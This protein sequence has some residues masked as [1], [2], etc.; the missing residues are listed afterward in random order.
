[1][2]KI[3]I[4]QKLGI[5]DEI[6][7]DTP[8]QRYIIISCF[9][10]GSSEDIGTGFID[11]ANT[12]RKKLEK[13]LDSYKANI[14]IEIY[15]IDSITTLVG[16]INKGNIKQLDI[17]S[18]GGTEHLVIGSG[19]GIGKRELLYASDLSKFNKDSFLKDA[20]ITF[21]GCK[22]ASNPSRFR[23]FIGKKCI[24]EEF[25]NY[26]KKCKVVGFTGGAIQ[27]SSPTSKP[28]INFIHKQGDDV[29]FVTWGTVKVFY[30]D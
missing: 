26:F 1:M 13:E 6:Q 29:W 30:E 27:A 25:A 9:R 12:L 2:P 19:E 17:F 23:K 18:H 10:G 5:E 15:N 8:V 11:A 28:D 16:I 22:T 21:W 3:K 24:A 4:K 7:I 14:N 20:I